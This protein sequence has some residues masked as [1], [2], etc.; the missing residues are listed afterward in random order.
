MTAVAER[1]PGDAAPPSLRATLRQLS[2]AQKGSVGAPLYS[3]FVNRPLGRALAAVA[4]HAGLTPNTVTAISAMFTA[5]GVALLA[6]V[7]PSVPMAMAVTGCLVLGYALDAADGQLARLRGGGSPAG[8]WLDH[9]VDAAK[10]VSLHLAVATGLYRF[11][12]VD[13]A[14][15]LIPLGFCVVDVVIFFAMVLNEALRAQQG[16]A[17]RAQGPAQGAGIGR[18][19]MALPTDYGLL[20]LVFTFYGVSSVF[21]P[22][23][24]A[25]GL[26]EAV[27]LALASVKWFREMDRL[28]R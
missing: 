24:A 14:V 26:A 4:F 13:P 27:F 1:R 18:S 19:L 28:P 15:L 7:S 17:T 8:E 25:L 23:Y 3:R 22:V 5:A 9:M 6:L 11:A 10:I 16:V 20:A 12:D 21:V 2:V